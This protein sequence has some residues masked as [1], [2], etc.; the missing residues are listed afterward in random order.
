MITNKAYH[1]I[2]ARLICLFLPLSLPIVMLQPSF[3]PSYRRNADVIPYSNTGPPRT[4]KSFISFRAPQTSYR[5]NAVSS[6]KASSEAKLLTIS[7]SHIPMWCP[8]SNGAIVLFY[9]HTA[10]M[11]YPVTKI[12]EPSLNPISQP[13]INHNE[14]SC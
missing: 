12:I 8:V 2:L 14:Y 13:L 3:R 5:R 1:F 10:E 11:R 7:F 9:C 4:C 6:C